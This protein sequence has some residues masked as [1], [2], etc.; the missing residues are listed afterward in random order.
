MASRG[1]TPN[2]SP[3]QERTFLQLIS[4]G[5]FP[6]QAAKKVGVTPQAISMRRKRD[7]VFATRVDEA[8]AT[9][10]FSLVAHVMKGAPKDWRAAMGLLERRFPKRWAKLETKL[11]VI[12]NAAAEANNQPVER[13]TGPAVPPTKD[14]LA[15]I[16][17]LHELAH[18]H[19]G[20][21]QAAASPAPA[22][23]GTET[24]TTG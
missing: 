19:L 20:P 21:K 24:Q 3:E 15:G 2:L 1:K 14:L 22:A 12:A 7:K 23:D 16:D 8:E 13:P 6:A 5:M 9:L 4:F 17:K 18:E 10:E 11:K